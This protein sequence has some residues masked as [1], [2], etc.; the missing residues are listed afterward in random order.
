VTTPTAL[1]LPGARYVLRDVLRHRA[2]QVAQYGLNEDL[3][4]GTGPHVRWLTGVSD[5]AAV[6]IERNLRRFYDDY[7]EEHGAPTWSLLIREELAETMQEDDPIRPREEAIQTA[8]L[9][10]SMVARI[11][12]DL[13]VVLPKWAT[14]I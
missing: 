8:A 1:W 14:E 11:D 7:V 9:L 4:Y 5:D 6:D 2:A 12:A 13:G 10:V 3:A